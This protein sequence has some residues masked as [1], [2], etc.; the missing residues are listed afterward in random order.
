MSSKLAI[1]STL[2]KIFLIILICAIII[3][4][5]IMNYGAYKKFIASKIWLIITIFA[6]SISCII[7]QVL[8]YY[9]N[10][11]KDIDIEPL[12]VSYV[13]PIILCI[14][15]LTFSHFQKFK[16]RCSIWYTSWYKFNN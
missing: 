14:I 5:D 9:S 13:I 8:Y 11:K 4:G 16:M 12:T 15:S 6:F 3:W 2:R 7:T 10:N 1:Y